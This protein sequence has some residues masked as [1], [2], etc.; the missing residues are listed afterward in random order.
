MHN[1]LPEQY[2][3]FAEELLPLLK[4]IR[5]PCLHAPWS[6]R[7]LWTHHSYRPDQDKSYKIKHLRKSFIC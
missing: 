1:M 6:S 7:T 3:K 5:H 2:K 4:K